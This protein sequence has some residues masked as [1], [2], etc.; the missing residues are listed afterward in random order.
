MM[1]RAGILIALLVATL[2]SIPSIGRSQN[3]GFTASVDRNPAGLGEEFTLSFTLTNAGAGGGKNMKLPDLSKF[4]M[5]A[6][7]NQ[8]TSMQFVNGNMSS[9]ATYSYVLQ[10]KELGTL[11]IGPASIDV[12]G[13][14]VQSNA[15]ALEV[16][17]A[18]SRPKQQAAVADASGQIGDNV[19]LKAVASKTHVLQGEQINLTFKLYTR[20]TIMNY[21]V[22]KTP[23]MT[24]FWGEDVETPKD[25]QLSQETVNGKQFR[26]GIIKKMALFATQS[27]TLEISPMEVQTQLQLPAPRSVDPFDAF[28]RDPFGRTTNYSVRSE[29][30]K[31]VVD[32]LPGGAPQEF[33]GAIGQFAMSTA[34]DKK[35]TRTN[36]P[37]SLKVSI[38]G[39]GNIKLLE[40][41]PLELPPDFEQYSPKV[42]ENISRSGEKISGSKTFEYLLIPRYPGLKTIKPVVFAFFDLAKHQ[43]IRLRS[44]EIELNVE[45]G[46]APSPGIA[47]SAREDV[48]VLSQD[49]RFIKVRSGSFIRAGEF[50]YRS[51]IFFMLLIL[52]LAGLA[53]MF[54]YTKSR[55]S[56][57]ADVAGYRNRKA[58]SVARKR[59]KVAEKSLRDTSPKA[60]ATV[61]T[62]VKFFS[63]VAGALWHYLGDKLG[64]P[65]AEFSI[66]RAVEGLTTRGAAAPLVEALR[67]LLEACDMV[68]F[69][70][71]TIDKAS[72]E[73]TYAEASRIIVELERTLSAQ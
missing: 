60:G 1:K 34:T 24:G 23:T 27:G 4:R 44:P 40:A 64:I 42:S 36:E 3:P 31:I 48:R 52:P 65:Q 62:G 14:T 9:S 68:R 2:G 11:V 30:L 15:L 49:I 21:G 18:A 73:R 53:G 50:V 10:P 66:E 39:T 13:K 29:P 67:E 57:L 69:A 38:S 59:L 45:Q 61:M 43:Y 6:G 37:V 8:S 46:S 41:P 54:V 25:V 55:R 7:P 12:G 22:Q 19:V 28:F 63:E 26:V 5:L 17:K 51:G 32:P 47:G 16:V 58:M 72:M 71:T 20:L 33:K 35:T 70:P 56:L